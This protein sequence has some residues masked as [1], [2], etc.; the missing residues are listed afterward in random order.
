MGAEADHR[1]TEHAGL[2]SERRGGT[3][4][5]GADGDERTKAERHLSEQGTTNGREDARQ[6]TDASHDAG[7]E[8]ETAGEAAHGSEDRAEHGRVHG[9]DELESV[10]QSVEDRQ[11]ERLQRLGEVDE[12]LAEVL[13]QVPHAG[14]DVPCRLKEIEQSVSADERV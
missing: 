13:R 7:Q 14:Q 11:G 2:G 12:Q 3:E 1:L 9:V 5:H 10:V 4:S 6:R 8:H